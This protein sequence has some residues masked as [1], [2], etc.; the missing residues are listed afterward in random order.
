M[1]LQNKFVLIKLDEAPIDKNGIIIPVGA[2]VKP[3][4]GIVIAAG[5][6]CSVKESDIVIINYE[7]GAMHEEG[8]LIEENN[9]VCVYKN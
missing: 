6:K 3:D 7:F 1:I 8:F 5:A 4:R 9:I 2:K